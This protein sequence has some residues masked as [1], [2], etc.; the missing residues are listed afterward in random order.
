MSLF[1][2]T[3][4]LAVL[5]QPDLFDGKATCLFELDDS[6]K[7]FDAQQRYFPAT[8]APEFD[9]SVFKAMAMHYGEPLQPGHALGYRDGQLLL[10]FTHN[11]PD[12]TLPVFWNEGR[13]VPWAPVFV[14]YDKEY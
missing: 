6:F 1:A 2:T 5:N 4:G 7:A 14:R 11:T 12:N 13:T 3:K 8:L 9:L 10:G